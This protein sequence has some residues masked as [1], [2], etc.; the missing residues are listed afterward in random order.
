MNVYGF[1]DY[2]QQGSLRVS[3]WMWFW[4]IYSMRHA[5]LWLGLSIAHSPDVMD[6]L[7]DE[8]HWAYLLCGIPG[9]MLLVDAGF[10][11]PQAGAFPRWVWRNGRWLLVVSI[12]LHVLIVAGMALGKPN[13]QLSTSQF[14]FFAIDFFGLR[15]ALK[16]QRVRD[17]FADFPQPAKDEKAV[18]EALKKAAAKEETGAPLIAE[19]IPSSSPSVDIEV[20]KV[21]GAEA[22]EVGIRYHQSGQHAQAERVY[23]QILANYPDNADALHLMGVLNHQRGV[24][25]EAE[26][27]ILRAISIQPHVA[28]YY[29]NLGRV[30]QAQG[31]MAEAIALYE[32]ALQIQ[33]DF[34]DAKVGLESLRGRSWLQA[35]N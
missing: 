10:R 5:I 30:Y 11:I 34:S 4:I 1:D 24:R 23:L 29:G 25:E 9:L 15:F 19:E 13:W 20:L 3:G 26:R 31:R 16:S 22:I 18:P 7:T 2:N 21:G 17:V 32:K 14:I 12:I 35:R 33:P 28:L 27:L 6:E 8:S